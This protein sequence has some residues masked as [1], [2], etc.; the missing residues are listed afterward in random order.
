LGL[1]GRF[2]EKVPLCSGF[3]KDT[4]IEK[5]LVIGKRPLERYLGLY[6]LIAIIDEDKAAR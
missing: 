2:E 6:G 1:T 4:E 3:G 5:I